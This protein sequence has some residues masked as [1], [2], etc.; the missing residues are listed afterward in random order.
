MCDL[1]F[2]F[3]E[4]QL[5]LECRVVLV[6]VLSDLEQH[7]DHVLNSLV[8][9]RLV[10]DAPELIVDSECDLRVHLFHVLANFL[11]QA[12]CDLHAVICGLV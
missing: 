10:K 7:F 3:H 8:D 11:R 6:F 9:I 1:I 12:N 4:I 2:F 5:L